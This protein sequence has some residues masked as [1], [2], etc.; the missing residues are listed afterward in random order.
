MK[1]SRRDLILR[2]G[3]AALM[4]IPIFRATRGFAAEEPPIRRMVTFFS[5]SG[6]RQDIF[7]P[8]GSPGNYSDGG[9]SVEG[10]S[11][12][13]LEPFLDRVIIP[14]GIKND[15]G[16]GDGHDAGS[17]SVLTGDYMRDPDGGT[18]SQYARGPSLDYH[19]SETVGA[20][21]PE[22]ML[23]TGTRLQVNRVSKWISYDENGRYRDYIQN[24]YTLYDRIFSH[25]VHSRCDGAAS[26]QE[27]LE[28]VRVRRRSVLDTV[29]EETKSMR[30]AYGM[31]RRERNKL[32]QMQ[33]G[34]RDIE[35]RLADP[36]SVASAFDA[37]RCESVRSAF[38]SADQVADRD[39]NFPELLS[40]QLDLIALAFELD[41]TRVATISLSLGGSGGAPMRWLSWQ[42]ANGDARPIE[43]SHHNVSHGTQRGVENYREKLKVIDRWNFEQFAGLLE[44]LDAID[45]GDGTVLD[46]SLVWY[47]SD[48]GNGHNH[49]VYDMPFVIAGRAGGGLP[50]GRYVEFA[51]QPPHQRLLSKFLAIM[52]GE[53]AAR[54]G[55]E[56][57][58]LNGP[59]E[60]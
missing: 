15:H 45:E 9:Y 58:T 20:S 22:R 1:V 3:P 28:R 31:G 13:P 39:D 32:D 14:R 41:I 57:S 8:T 10:T 18:G 54:W 16:P 29:L 50:T 43:A 4:A 12:A 60:L 33:Q 53:D 5:S 11:L 25:I 52:S 27:A 51:D 44:R 47:A 7:W 23:L 42:D 37:V 30:A 36:D 26:A 59:L 49:S 40:L 38:E 55:R 46:N 17:V 56:A 34:I 2:Y 21:S 48:V 6:V 35:R 19:L 24:P